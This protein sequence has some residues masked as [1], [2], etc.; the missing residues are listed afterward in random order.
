M[1]YTKINWQENTPISASNLSHMDEGIAN[2]L[3]KDAPCSRLSWKYI[4]GNARI[5]VDDANT[6]NAAVNYADFSNH[7]NSSDTVGGWRIKVVSQS[8]FDSSKKE[9]N[10]LYFIY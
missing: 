5:V 9:T 2:S 6:S 4:N 8:D 10:T 7:S 3:S 1:A